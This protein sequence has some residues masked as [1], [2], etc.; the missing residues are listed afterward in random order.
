MH[1]EIINWLL[2]IGQLIADLCR[3]FLSGNLHGIGAG[4]WFYDSLNKTNK[5]YQYCGS[6]K[7]FRLFPISNPSF[8][9][10]NM[11]ILYQ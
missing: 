2:I 5:L 9:E 4:W 11:L 6:N 10:S 1:F 8:Y 3:N 7:E